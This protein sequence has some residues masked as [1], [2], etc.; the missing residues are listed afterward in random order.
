MTGQ[1]PD[2]TFQ[3]L[4]GYDAEV[5]CV[6]M[7]WKGYATSREFRDA[8]ERVLSTFAERNAS[9]LLGD[10]KD[11]VLIG[12]EDQNWLSHHWIPRMIGVGLR[13]VALVSPAFYFNKV[14]VE[15]VGE[16]L[17]PNQLVLKYFED[18]AAARGWLAAA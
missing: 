2:P 10:A 8:S 7:T 3:C 9:K 16:R 15:T 11:F 14:A 5:P 13:T 12:S 6:T 4:I 17:D 1:P 18:G